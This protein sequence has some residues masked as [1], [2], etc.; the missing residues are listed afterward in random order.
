MAGSPKQAVNCICYLSNSLFSDWNVVVSQIDALHYGRR[1]R[2]QDDPARHNTI[3]RPHILHPPTHETHPPSQI[4]SKANMM[5][6]R[7]LRTDTATTSFFRIILIESKR[8][9]S[10]LTSSSSFSLQLPIT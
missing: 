5:M 8:Q 7:L 3:I 2:I 1:V 10:T 4:S 6:S 9:L